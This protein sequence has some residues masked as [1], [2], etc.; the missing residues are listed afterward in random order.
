MI[1]FFQHKFEPTSAMLFGICDDGANE[2]PPAYLD[3]TDIS[4][5][6]AIVN[7]PNARDIVFRPI[8]N[9]IPILK[10]DILHI[11]SL[12]GDDCFEPMK[13][14]NE[15][16]SRADGMIIY[17]KNIVFI[18]LKTKRKKWIQGALCQLIVTVKV[19]N[20]FHN[21]D[22]YD[23]VKAYAC[24]KGKGPIANITNSKRNILANMGVRV[25][26]D[27]RIEIY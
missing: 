24:N 22:Q 13:D 12:I 20:E 10:I 27:K 1:D 8:D 18:E 4:K 15:S 3:Y 14:K 7:N 11:K 17:D 26:I 23:S 25:F 9:C 2:K 5:W 19:F 6:I 21:L 16:A